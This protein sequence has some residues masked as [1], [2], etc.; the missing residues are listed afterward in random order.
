M[1]RQ[2]FGLR[3]SGRIGDAALAR[4]IAG[5]ISGEVMFDAFSRG[6]YATDASHYQI[7]PIGVVVPR[8]TEDVRAVIDIARDEGVPVLARGGGTSQCGQTVA[9]AVVVEVQPF[10]LDEQ[11]IPGVLGARREEDPFLAYLACHVGRH[12]PG[13][14]AGPWRAFG[15]DVAHRGDVAVPPGLVGRVL[16]VRALEDLCGAGVEG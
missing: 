3:A 10:V 8:S 16:E 4:R 2:N 7:E 6:R 13:P 14:A 12:R 5:G 1:P 9:E 15:H 11:H